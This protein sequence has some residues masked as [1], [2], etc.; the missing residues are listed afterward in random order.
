ME[1]MRNRRNKKTKKEQIKRLFIEII[2]RLIY[3]TIISIFGVACVLLV[4][5][6]LG[7]I[8]ELCTVSKI[9]CICYFIVCG[10]IILR[11]L[12]KEVL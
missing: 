6:T 4:F 9:Y 7:A 11:W 5:G 3:Y 8:V 1:K 12:L 10:G 2:A